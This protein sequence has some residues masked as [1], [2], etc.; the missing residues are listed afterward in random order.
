MKPYLNKISLLRFIADLTVVGFTY[1]L[2][3]YCL[4]PGTFTDHTK[5]KL[6]LLIV[7]L[8]TWFFSGT[9][10]KLYNEN[11]VKPGFSLEIY[12]TLKGIIILDIAIV[13]VSYFTQPFL[14]YN[15]VFLYPVMLLLCFATE[16]YIIN[17]FVMY[18][19]KH[20]YNLRHVVIL[21]NGSNAEQFYK[22]VNTNPHLGYDILGYF[23][24]GAEEED[25][26]IKYLGE[27]CDLP[28]FLNTS[29]VNEVIIATPGITIG[30]IEE[31]TYMVDKAGIRVRIIPDFHFQFYN[32]YEFKQF[33][34]IPTVS[35]RKEPLEETY[36]KFTKR[37]FDIV[38]SLFVLIFIC[39]WLF[40]IIALIIKSG[41]KGPVLFRQKRLGRD[42]KEF[43][44]LKFRSMYVNNDSDKVMA[45]KGDRRITPIGSFLRKT[46]LDEFP[47]FWNVLMGHMSIVGPRPHM[48]VQ[49][50]QYQ[51]I[52]N[53][54]LVRQ[55]IK[56]GIT[57]WA[58]VNGYRGEIETD[59]DIK[60]RVSYDIWYLENWSFFLD[61]KIIYL[62]VWNIFK[63]EDKAY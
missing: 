7:L 59:L 5:A 61:I 36:N 11:R 30:E 45:T 49:N 23:K 20:G 52:I 50:A 9:S 31:I 63:G 51:A 16:K 48:T 19:R 29:I 37:T 43:W 15:F 57:G 38:F 25:T 22:L 4:D 8:T 34:N 2:C 12:K 56:P 47:Q 58:Q 17:R 39:S 41:S 44:C 40:P 18:L 35:L 54:Y 1:V 3:I 10:N 28:S 14:P 27:K 42:R 21:G 46:S 55:L 62:T 13:V 32:R 6:F 53:N 33:G 24:D 60:N 26:S